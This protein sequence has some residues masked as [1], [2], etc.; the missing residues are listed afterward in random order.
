MTWRRR[1]H[2]GWRKT[3]NRFPEFEDLLYSLDLD[4]DSA[5]IQVD[6]PGHIPTP[7]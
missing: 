1:R 5:R 3:A 2:R 4:L 7:F 6:A